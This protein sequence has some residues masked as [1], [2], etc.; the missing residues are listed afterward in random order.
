MAEQVDPV[1][2]PFSNLEG[3]TRRRTKELPDTALQRIAGENSPSQQES[4]LLIEPDA[5]GRASSSTV[6][7]ISSGPNAVA[8]QRGTS[9]PWKTAEAPLPRLAEVAVS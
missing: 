6:V 4:L 5:E 1:A 2:D 9:S 7:R 3:P 8:A